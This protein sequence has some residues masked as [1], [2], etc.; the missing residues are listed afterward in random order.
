MALAIQATGTTQWFYDADGQPNKMT[1][2]QGTILYEYYA[3]TGRLDDLIESVPGP[4]IA[5]HYVY[6]DAG[7]VETVS[8]FGETTTFVYDDASRPEKMTYANGAYAKY[9]Y[10]GRSRIT[11]VEHFTSAHSLIR[12]E[13]N[14][15]DPASRITS[16]Y[17]G[18]AS[19]GLTTTFGYDDAGQLTSESSSGYSDGV[20]RISD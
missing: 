19:G 12:K 3:N 16:R 11:A 18:P 8:K 7:Q 2:P 17:E 4:D 14:V 1:S 10:D 15:Y 20:G 6:D 13:T 9:T 5:T